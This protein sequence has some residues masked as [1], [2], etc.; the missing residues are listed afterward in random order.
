MPHNHQENH[1]AT[2]QEIWYEFHID[3]LRLW[4]Y[5][6][7]NKIHAYIYVPSGHRISYKEKQLA[8]NS[9]YPLAQEAIKEVKRNFDLNFSTSYPMKIWKFQGMREKL[10]RPLITSRKEIRFSIRELRSC[11]EHESYRHPKIK[12]VYKSDHDKYE[13]EAYNR[14]EVMA[15]EHDPDDPDRASS[16]LRK[17]LVLLM[18]QYAKKNTTLIKPSHE[19]NASQFQAL[20]HRAADDL[21]IDDSGISE[22]RRQI[23]DALS[24]YR[25]ELKK[26]LQNI[27][28]EERRII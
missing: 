26:G 11:L 4:D 3:E 19:L 2:V 14:R 1:Y 18:Y 6:V 8:D 15:R 20:I 10:P 12:Y 13:L 16:S 22:C 21:N 25:N 17:I 27:L 7:H 5:V 24:L 9:F 23:A 28:D